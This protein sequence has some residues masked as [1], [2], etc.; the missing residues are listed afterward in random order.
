MLRAHRQAWAWQDEWVGLTI[1]D[2]RKLEEEAAAYLQ[3]VMS[4][5]KNAQPTDSDEEEDSNSD[6]FFDCI[7]QPSPHAVVSDCRGFK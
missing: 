5:E 3:Q 1:E 2:I 4:S 7:D 6:I